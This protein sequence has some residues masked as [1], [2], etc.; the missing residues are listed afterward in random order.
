MLGGQPMPYYP[1][2]WFNPSGLAPGQSIPNP[3]AALSGQQGASAAASTTA[4]GVASSTTHPD[5]NKADEKDSAE[6]EDTLANTEMAQ[7]PSTPKTPKR[8]NVE[9]SPFTPATAAIF[10][11]PPGSDLAG[12]PI[13]AILRPD[14]TI[15]P[16]PLFHSPGIELMRPPKPP[17]VNDEIDP[18][19]IFRL[20]GPPYSPEKPSYSYAA[21]I[22]QALNA[23]HRKRACLD[24]IYLYISTVYPYYKRGEQ[25]WQNSIRHN[26]SQNSSF[27]RLKHPSGGQHGEWAIR[28]E[29][30][31]CFI[32]GGFVRSARPVEHGRKRRRKGAFDDDSDLEE[33]ISPRKRPK[34]LSGKQSS[35]TEADER[36][37]PTSPTRPEQA[38]HTA[39]EFHL[40]SRQEIMARARSN[41]SSIPTTK[42]SQR[43]GKKET[44]SKP[45]VAKRKKKK[46][47][48]SE[49]E[50]V[51]EEE[52]ESE[53]EMDALSPLFGKGKPLKGDLTLLAPFKRR[54]DGATSTDELLPFEGLSSKASSISPPLGSALSELP[55]EPQ[56]EVL[57]EEEDEIEASDGAEDSVQIDSHTGSQNLMER[58]IE[59]ARTKLNIERVICFSKLHWKLLT[60]LGF[61]ATGKVQ[62]CA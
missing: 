17:V 1:P 48:E 24:H 33:D 29:D 53:F 2:V 7:Q 28:E 57:S 47:S 42:K 51:S 50:L 26:L 27:T 41:D 59:S 34:K 44:R 31:H 49:I 21:L 32:D 13:T 52:E 6:N 19:T 35:R 62:T 8:K 40:P 36:H 18:S 11:S 22:G 54:E 37:R 25:A 58:T 9:P 12:T 61:Q 60:E 16:T 46:Y 56:S 14:G 38:A 43:K 55:S 20:P 45:S 10:I 30:K 15:I 3:W 39:E 23:A 5:K 4:S